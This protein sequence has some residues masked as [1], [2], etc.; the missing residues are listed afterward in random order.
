MGVVKT[1]RLDA[2]LASRGKR[3][4]RCARCD[5]A[6]SAPAVEIGGRPNPIDLRDGC[7]G[8]PAGVFFVVRTD[9]VWNGAHD[10]SVVIARDDVRNTE[11]CGVRNGCCGPSGLDGPNLGC[12]HD[13]VVGTEVADCWTPHFVFFDAGATVVR[14]VVESDAP[15]TEG[16][17]EV[18]VCEYEPRA[19]P[20]DPWPFASWLHEKLALPD[21]YGDD[22]ERLVRAR[23]E[24]TD[25]SMVV[26]VR[27]ALESP[28]APTWVAIRDRVRACQPE[29][30]SA[31][32]TVVL[33]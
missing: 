24:S 12:S 11:P 7:D 31:R 14:D 8:I 18:D 28:G 15:A 2:D 17:R 5:V 10:G 4:V 19:T 16:D 23:I 20:D 26:L 13:H 30:R 32:F 29:G 3:I 27:G 33:G 9:D 6:L 1:D 21:W 25:R 22:L